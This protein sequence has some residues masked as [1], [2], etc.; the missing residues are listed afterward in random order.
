MPPPTMSVD[1]A[2][3]RQAWPDMT[4]EEQREFLSLFIEHVVIGRGRRGSRSV[5]LSRDD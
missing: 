4:L 1:I 2:T 5:D 3:A